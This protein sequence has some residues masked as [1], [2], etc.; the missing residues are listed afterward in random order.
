MEAKR[1]RKTTKPKGRTKAKAKSKAKGKSL[2][3]VL[4]VKSRAQPKK[5]TIR[6]LPKNTFFM[7][8]SAPQGG[9]GSKLLATTLAIGA[10]GVVGY[11][12]LQFWKKHKESRAANLDKELD[13]IQ[14]SP[15]K[16][17]KLPPIPPY[18]PKPYT[19][20]K[21]TDT[22]S[23]SNSGGGGS[24]SRNDDFPLKKG[25]KGDVVRQMQQALIDKYGRSA[26]PKYGADGDFGNET[27]TALKKNGLPTIVSESVFNILTQGGGGGSSSS[28]SSPLAEQL[29]QAAESRNFN[30]VISLLKKIGSKD[31]YQQVS[32]SFMAMRLNGVR[33]TL[34]NGVLS[35]FHDESQKQQI[36]ME[37]I[38]MGLQYRNNKF[39]LSGF[40]GKPLVTKVPATVWTSPTQSVQV[41]AMM[42]IGN[43]V[44][45]RLDYTLFEN[46]GKYCLIKTDAVKYL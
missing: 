38:R 10:A 3:K 43:E 33:Q 30:G 21:D 37:F 31:Q 29:H 40:D 24:R 13:K 42:V 9:G 32:S 26:L 44:T 2:G 6:S 28:G 35:S 41:P 18:T 25:S 12:G 36:R 23:G 8:A 20:P 39:S 34:V 11:L 27:L 17:I 19:P 5:Q 14:P 22:H 7:P 4:A 16:D 46:N 45:T 15:V 1:K